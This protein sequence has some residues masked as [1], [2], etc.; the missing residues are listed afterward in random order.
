MSE[1]RFSLIHRYSVTSSFTLSTAARSRED[2]VGSPFFCE[3]WC[4][5][6]C[7]NILSDPSAYSISGP[8]LS[9]RCRLASVVSSWHIDSSFVPPFLI[10]DSQFRWKGMSFD[11]MLLRRLGAVLT[12]RV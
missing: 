12:R 8:S 5:F 11:Q 3:L 4:E 10:L 1:E 6:E 9:P 7:L 2:P